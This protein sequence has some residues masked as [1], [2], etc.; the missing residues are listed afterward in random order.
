[1]IDFEP[2]RGEASIDAS[3]PLRFDA[4][5]RRH[6]DVSTLRHIDTSSTLHEGGDGS[7]VG[8]DGGEP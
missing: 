3:T 2:L 8:G 6:V 7:G 1:M 5:T 4:L